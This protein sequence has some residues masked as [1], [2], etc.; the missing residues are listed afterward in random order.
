M[1]YK[2]KFLECVCVDFE[3]EATA[4]KKLS[5]K[6]LQKYWKAWGWERVTFV[7]YMRTEIT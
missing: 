4:N 7:S 3:R 2:K 1:L 6:L 5:N